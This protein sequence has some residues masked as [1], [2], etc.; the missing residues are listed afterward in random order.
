MRPKADARRVQGPRGRQARAGRLRRGD[1]R[2]ARPAARALGQ[3]RAPSSA[4]PQRGDFVVM[5]F[6]G[7]LDGVPFAGGEGRDQMIEL[8]SGRLVPGFEEQLE[9]AVAGEERTVTITF[10]DDYPARPSSPAR[11][12]SSPSRSRRS[13]PSSCPSSTTTSPPRPASTRSTSCA[14]TS[15][16]AWPRPRRRGSRPSSA[17]RR[18]TPRSPTATVEVPDALVE[19]R[20]RELWD[21]MLHSL[22]HQGIDRETYLRI[23]GRDRGGDRSSRPS[24]TPSRRCAA[25]PCWPRSSR[26][27]ARAH[28]GGDARG[29][30]ARP[31]RRRSRRRP[32]SC[33]SACSTN[34]PP[35]QPQGRPRAAQG[36]GP[37][38]RV[39]EA[40]RGRAAQIR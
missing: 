12:P 3:A 19:A 1:R 10:P 2:G 38:G 17:R 5:D 23:S 34:G 27:R 14:R 37:G 21:Q 35:R 36:A 16:R 7:T 40:G 25:R 39:R 33:S 13:R 24:R 11:R 32:R 29:G 30:R 22:S 8:G 9:G 31:R 4:R 15:A 6:A 28:R 20:A 26:P 18:S